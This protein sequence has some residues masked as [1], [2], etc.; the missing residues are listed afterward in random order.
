MVFITILEE[1]NIITLNCHK[2]SK[3][4]EF[5]QL[6][7]DASTMDIIKKPSKPDIDASVTYSH[8]CDLIESGA[9]LPKESVAAWG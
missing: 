3:D 9:P 4:G 2:G 8:I 6:V 5:F 1:G 7:V